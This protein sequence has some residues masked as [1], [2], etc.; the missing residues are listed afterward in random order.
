MTGRV[1]PAPRRVGT[2]GGPSLSPPSAERGAAAVAAFVRAGRVA[3]VRTGAVRRAPTAYARR[4]GLSGRRAYDLVAAVHETTADTVRHG[5]G[6]G[7]VPLRGDRDQVI[8]EIPAS[9]RVSRAH[10]GGGCGGRAI[11][12][13]TA[14]AP[15]APSDGSA[16]GARDAFSPPRAV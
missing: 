4:P 2:A 5:G 13:A 6:Q 15:R 3:R 7:A 16:S 12:S 9:A 11:R 8:R 10:P 14:S 1:H